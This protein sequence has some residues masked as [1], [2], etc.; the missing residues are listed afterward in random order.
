MNRSS[1]SSYIPR[2]VEDLLIDIKYI[3]G[4]PPGCK[5]DIESRSY[6]DATNIFSRCYRTLFTN[7]RRITAFEFINSTIS[8]AI[9]IAYENTKWVQII[10]DEIS[11]MKNAMTNLKHVYHNS[12]R[13]KG[14]IETIQI[15]INHDAFM[16]AI[17]EY[18]E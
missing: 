10:C 9:K 4:L 16:N 12:P 5:Y 7:E 18:S 8:E 3:S 1:L 14:T 15:R 17:D 13:S 6:T 11:N 2:D